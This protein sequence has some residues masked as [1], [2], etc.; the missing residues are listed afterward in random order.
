MS[1]AI[2]AV[3]SGGIA[4]CAMWPKM[5]DTQSQ[6]IRL[7]ANQSVLLDSFFCGDREIGAPFKQFSDE[8]TK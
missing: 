6:C 2:R 3:I 4:P 7:A 8:R 1:T 5:S